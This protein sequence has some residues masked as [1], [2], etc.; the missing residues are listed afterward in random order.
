MSDSI[1]KVA[2]VTGS[3][4]GIGRAI[5]RQLSDDGFAVVV[6]GTRAKDS[7][8]DPVTWMD[9]EG[10]DTLYVVADVSQTAD[11]DHLVK[12]VVEHYGRID[13]LVNNAGVAPNVRNDILEMTE[14]S[15]DRVLNINC[16]GNMFMTQAVANE[17]VRE[18]AA[19]T[20][21]GGIVINISSCSSTVSSTSRGEYCVSKAGI[22]MLTKLYADRLA[23]ENIN[24]YEIRP[25]V[26]MTDMTSTVHEKY[27]KLIEQGTFPIA[28]WGYPEDIAFAASAFASGKFPYTTGNSIDVD[29]GFHIQRL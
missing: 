24:V 5:A 2:V 6:V 16:K 11:R 20:I 28:R 29:G 13:V 4:R 25:G 10:R 15:W 18:R 22:S 23:S 12:T 17:M 14:D 7:Y 21:E 8:G 26:I 1:K 3:T 9:E 19:G 27:N